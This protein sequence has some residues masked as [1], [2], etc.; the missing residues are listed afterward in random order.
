MHG[1]NGS[2]QSSQANA[3]SGRNAHEHSQLKCAFP[4]AC[5]PK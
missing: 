2:L 3:I 1:R 5:R 4:D